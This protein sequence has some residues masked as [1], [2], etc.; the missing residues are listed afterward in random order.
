MSSERVTHEDL[1]RYLDGELPPSERE[2]I[3]KA[4]A[5]S[6]EL[7]REV[8]VYRSLKDGLS[9]LHP[10]ARRSGSI[11]SS[12]APRLTRPVGW[13]LVVAGASAWTAYGVYA[14]VASPAELWE[15]LATGGIVIGILVLLASVIMER[16]REFLT[17]P[18]RDVQ[19]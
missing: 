12:V 6:T 5:E 18:Y 14:Y 8:A 3:E 17:D 19:R 13:T 7:R 4:I 10:G 16:Y 2:R 9:S 15:K 11:W 1:M